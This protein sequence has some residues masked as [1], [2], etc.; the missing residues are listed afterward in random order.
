MLYQLS[1]SRRIRPVCV[2]VLRFKCLEAALK[3]YDEWWGEQDS[4]L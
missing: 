4:N 3:G 1:Y 2:R